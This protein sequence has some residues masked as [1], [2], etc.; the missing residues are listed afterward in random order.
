MVA[1]AAKLTAGVGIEKRRKQQWQERAFYY[2]HHLGEVWY[3]AQFYARALRKVELYVAERNDQDGTLVRTE[4]PAAISILE[5]VNGADGSRARILAAY[6]R[7]MFLTGECYLIRNPD[8]TWEA[9]SVTEVV[10]GDDGRLQR[11]RS[12]GSRNPE[13]LALPGDA[14]MLTDDTAIAYRLWRPDPQHSD[15]PDGP[16]RGVLDECEE[17]LVKS[18]AVRAQEL[19]RLAS[20]GLLLV[21]AELDQE[22]EDATADADDAEQVS[23]LMRKL[24]RAM[25]DSIEQEGS[26]SA[27]IPIII[28]GAG[29]ALAELR[30]VSLYD[31]SRAAVDANERMAVVKR[32]AIGLDMPPEVL[33]GVE[34]SNHWTAWQISEDTWSAHVEPVVI[35]LC[36]DLTSSLLRPTLEAEGIQDPPDARYVV[37]YDESRAVA[38]PDRSKIALEVHAAQALSDEA[39]REAA[40]FDE[41]DAPPVTAPVVTPI[42]PVEETEDVGPPEQAAV[43]AAAEL[44]VCRAR[45]I[46]GSRLRTRLSEGDK[47]KQRGVPNRMLAAAVGRRD[48]DPDA[49]S[50]VAGAGEPFLDTLRRW[51]VPDVIAQKLVLETEAHAARTLYDASYPPV[52]KAVEGVCAWIAL[53]SST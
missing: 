33:L 10:V 9:V 4:N 30:H 40:G 24:S 7:L 41:D 2:Y 18:R 45:E 37:W 43:V 3:A 6:G 39:L 42:V 22:D 34:D 1:S 50:L 28:S 35:D 38:R 19:S 12:A 44:L 48:G 23:P 20:N 32:I 36:G 14:G 15:E 25:Q 53:A 13:V 29:E 46:A 5:E 21:P 11:Y 26:A 52:P 49:D 51:H 8:G 17:L 31:P 47:A 16:M 27:V